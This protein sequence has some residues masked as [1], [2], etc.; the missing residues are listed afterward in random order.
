MREEPPTAANTSSLSNL[1]SA[2]YARDNT[3]QNSAALATTFN[4]LLESLKPVLSPTPTPP[5][6]PTPPAPPLE[7]LEVIETGNQQ[8]Q[9]QQQQNNL[10]LLS[11]AH[12]QW[13]D[14]IVRIFEPTSSQHQQQ[15]ESYL[16]SELMALID[17]LFY[18]GRISQHY[19]GHLLYM[20]ELYARLNT[21]LAA[22][23]ATDRRETIEVLSL[24]LE[25][26]VIPRM[27]FVEICLSV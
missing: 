20:N 15:R 19:H 13:V 18:D 24:L 26:R 7:T 3:Q 22:A 12:T 5:M 21:L 8:Q 17:R 14:R 27:I 23:A 1:L 25:M 4:E 2:L 10:A 6:P 11:S 16:Y 9:Q